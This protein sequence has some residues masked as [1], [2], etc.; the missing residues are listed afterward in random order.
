[1]RESAG[2]ACSS[3]LLICSPRIDPWIPLDPSLNA[4]E[5]SGFS[6]VYDWI[7]GRLVRSQSVA[8]VISMNYVSRASFSYRFNLSLLLN[9]RLS[10]TLLTR[11]AIQEAIFS[12]S[13]AHGPGCGTRKGL[14][15]F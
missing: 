1:M 4:E 5:R 7:Y 2:M 15:R 12:Q 9:L 3:L 8:S 10:T 6:C 11:N 13:L 14:L